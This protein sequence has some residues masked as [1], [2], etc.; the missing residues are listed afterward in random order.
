M[1]R[2]TRSLIKNY[3]VTLF[4]VVIAVGGLVLAIGGA[5]F[6]FGAFDRAF[7]D[8]GGADA[9]QRLSSWPHDVEPTAVKKLS[10]KTTSAID[11]HSSW[12]RIE[13]TEDA[14]KQWVA[15]AHSKR[16]AHLRSAS[17]LH[18]KSEGIVRELSVIPWA[19]DDTEKPPVWWNPPSG[20]CRATEVT[21]WYKNYDSGIGQ[22]TYSIIDP[23]AKILWIYEFSVQHRI[24]WQHGNMPV[25]S[26]TLEVAE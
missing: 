7:T 4:I 3:S 5:N 19:Y 10:F 15:D 11:S 8:L 25:D 1:K 26:T 18:E 13:A 21:I 23:T 14:I 9:Q 17:R 24:L 16:A 22:G 12:Y 6:P 2:Q 20:Q